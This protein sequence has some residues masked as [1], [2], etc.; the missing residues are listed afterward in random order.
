M[1]K[2]VAS[3][4]DE[5]LLDDNHEIP[6][7]VIDA[8]ARA[9]ELGVRFVPATGRPFPSV[10]GVLETLS[11]AGSPDDYVVSFNGGCLTNNSSDEPLTKCSLSWE[12]AEA[13]FQA[14]RKY[15]VCMHIN[16]LDPVYLYNY[17]PEERAYIDGRMNIIETFEPTLGF[18]ADKGEIVVK[19]VFMDLDLNYLRRIE[20]EM[21]EAGISC[22]LDVYYSGNRYLEFN[23]PG[24][25]KGAGLARL[26]ERLGISM[27]E[28][29][30]VGDNS[31]DVSMLA[32]AGLGCAVAN[33]TDE[34]KANANY[35]CQADNNAGAV[36]E[37]IEKFILGQ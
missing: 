6:Q 13:I 18:L 28:V 3:D 17:V 32:A 4:L 25:N 22:G 5:T 12:T 16:T 11:L 9:R 36:G 34:A 14:G 24:V 7:R 27:D 21:A 15:G 23:A 31:N 1:Y 35:V 37:V 29:I 19:I 8:V 33:A 26:A 2:L 20:K 10:R 30:A